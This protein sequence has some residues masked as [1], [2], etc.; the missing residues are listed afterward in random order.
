MG[1]HNS[2][3][4]SWPYSKNLLLSE[5]TM[6]IEGWMISPL[7]IPLY[8]YHSNSHFKVTIMLSHCFR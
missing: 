4:E 6:C 2:Y 8:L 7:P 3:E 1:S 5:V